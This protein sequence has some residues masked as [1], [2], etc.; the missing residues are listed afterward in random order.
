M[1]KGLITHTVIYNNDH[2]VLI[3]KRSEVNDVLP[4]YWDI[5]GG[6]LEN[7]ENPVA[8]AIRE[9][10]EETD[11]DVENPSLYF[12]KSNIDEGKNKQFVTLVFLAKYS[13]GEITLRPDAHEE[14]AWV[15]VSEIGNYK[16]VDYLVE[17]LALLVSKKHGILSF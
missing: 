4:G 9:P 2:K 3:I 16:T 5:P 1:D 8:G 12:E 17:C 15:S 11:L 6:T 13:G 7:G 14:Y 10:K